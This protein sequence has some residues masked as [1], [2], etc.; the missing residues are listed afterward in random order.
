[1]GE[2]G[3]LQSILDNEMMEKRE[4]KNAWIPVERS[5]R[6]GLTDN[7]SALLEEFRI[8]VPLDVLPYTQMSTSGVGDKDAAIMARINPK[9]I[10]E[11]KG[12]G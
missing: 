3:Y 11:V 7:S 10:G 9:Q 2:R 4:E 1:M 8:S 6:R 12:Y 5:I